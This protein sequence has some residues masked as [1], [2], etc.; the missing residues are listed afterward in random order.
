ML[1]SMGLKTGGFR[2][3]STIQVVRPALHGLM[4]HVS[5]HLVVFHT[6]F[7]SRWKR[8]EEKARGTATALLVFISVT[9]MCFA[10]G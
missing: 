3:L 10:V 5:F 8:G 7:F 1:S 9:I 4:H 6:D 2:T